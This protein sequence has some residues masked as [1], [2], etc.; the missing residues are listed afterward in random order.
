MILIARLMPD[1]L[2]KYKSLGK[3][4]TG[5]MADVLTNAAGRQKIQAESPVRPLLSAGCAQ[6]L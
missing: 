1:V 4:Y 5:I 6:Y 2:A 3:G